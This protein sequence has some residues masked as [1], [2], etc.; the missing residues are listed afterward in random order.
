[1]AD[2][3]TS[4]QRP[5][6]MSGPG[7][8]GEFVDGVGERRSW[9]ARA[10]ARMQLRQISA[11]VATL[12]AG[13]VVLMSPLSRD[14][15]QQWSTLVAW[16]LVLAVASVEASQHGWR[17]LVPRLPRA[18]LYTALALLAVALLYAAYGLARGHPGRLVAWEAQPYLEFC[19]F[20]IVSAAVLKT[21]RDAWLVVWALVAAATIKA[22]YDVL[23]MAWGL[24]RTQ[25]SLE[26]IEAHRIVDAVPFLI[27]PLALFA[28]AGYERGSR[29]R[30]ALL[31]CALLIIGVLA[32]TLT[33]T[34]WLGFAVGL[35]AAAAVERGRIAVRAL[36]PLALGAA[37]LAVAAP[38]FPQGVH[39]VG[40]RIDFTLQ[41]IQPH[42]K[43]NSAD[44]IAERRVVESRLAW[45]AAKRSELVGDGFGARIYIPQKYIAHW[46]EH[47]NYVASLHDYYLQVLLNAGLLGLVTLLALG[48]TCVATVG[49][50]VRRE[51]VPVTRAL[52]AGVL[53]LVVM[54]AIQMLSYSFPTTFHIAAFVAVA[55]ALVLVE[56][57]SPSEAAGFHR[58]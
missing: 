53:A 14:G 9:L 44:P 5:F 39:A 8:A 21:H 28:A 55:V 30:R 32:V 47:T 45:R 4:K 25:V 29:E 7:L 46:K 34:Y 23:I 37:V 42:G 57:R 38:F 48:M 12:A 17:S 16:L 6:D 36:A 20:L 58:A 24:L 2:L 11:S 43:A 19:A 27:A 49:R 31:V 56:Q 26:Q 40:S 18:I 51:H 33:R 54:E 1:L 13:L 50:R 15:R 22:T 52:A 3:E 35:G 41:Q 10:A